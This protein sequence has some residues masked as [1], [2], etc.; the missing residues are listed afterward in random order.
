VSR[1]P[2]ADAAPAATAR[3]RFVHDGFAAS[4]PWYDPL[5]RVFSFGLDGR[6]RRACLERCAFRSGQTVLDVATG[7]GALVL[8]AGGALAPGGVAVGADF[9]RAMLE[10]GRRKVAP[11]S[12]GAV[13]WVQGRA[14]ALP[15]ATGAFDCV[16]LGFVLRHLDDLAGAFRE[17]VRVLRPGGRLVILEWTRPDAAIPRALWLG[18]MRWVVAP[19]VRL[20]SRDGRVG[21]LAAHLPRSIAGFVS[22]AALGRELGHHGVR[23]LEVRS[24]LL[25]LVSLCVGIKVR[26]GGDG[27]RPGAAVGADGH[28]A[29]H[30][31]AGRRTMSP[32]GG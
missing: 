7:T 32:V 19:L 23:L 30:A 15:F 25:G 26:T 4:A 29:I 24:S 16:M 22:G 2:A 6:W 27:S 10:G 9:C 28:G 12:R 18:Y 5:T 3:S 17:M 11:G 14:E 1:L 20:V 31:P 21:E 8:G 13:A